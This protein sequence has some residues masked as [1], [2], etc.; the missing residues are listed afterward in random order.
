[1]KIQTTR[2]GE[3]EGPE[4]LIFNFEFPVIGY[5]DEKEYLIVNSAQNELFQWLQSTKTPELA[6]AITCASYFNIEYAFELPD[7]A[8]E[9]LDI[10]SVEDLMVFNIAKIPHNNPSKATINLLA[11]IIFNVKNHKAGQ[12]I[13]SGTDFQ[14]NKPIFE[15]KK[16]EAG[17]KK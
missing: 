9:T 15:D 2:F 12:V 14:V 4:E 5:N 6:F 1:M 7:V 16:K 13:L 3:I 10:Q 11:P 17:E 8:Q